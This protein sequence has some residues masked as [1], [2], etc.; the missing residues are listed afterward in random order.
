MTH[1]DF[2]ARLTDNYE[3][4]LMA[5]V[6]RYQ[7]SRAP[8]VKVTPAVVSSLHVEL[9]RLSR[10]FIESANA[11]IDNYMRPLLDGASEQLHSELMKRKK[12]VQALTRRMVVENVRQVIQ[13]T[14]TGI[15]S[16][17]DMLKTAS[18]GMGLLV[19]RKTGKIEFKAT[20]MSGRKWDAVKLMRVVVRDYAYQSWI[21]QQIDAHDQ[22]HDDLMIASGGQIFSIRGSE[23]LPKVEDVRRALFHPNS[24]AALKPYVPS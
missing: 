19:Q 8:G 3:L 20:D 24:N 15:G 5:L 4:L 22:L 10:I 18:G 21:D 7:E 11:E 6:G 17:I 1:D 9:F 16:Y 14:K 23:G 13:L 12:E 2:A